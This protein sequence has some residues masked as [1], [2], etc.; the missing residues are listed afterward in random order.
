[1]EFSNGAVKWVSIASLGVF[2]IAYAFSFGPVSWLLLSEIFPDD[3]R[4][5][6]I[7]IAT[8]FNWSGNLAVSFSF[9]SA[10]ESLGFSTTFFIYAGISVL[11]FVF[12][13]S[14]VPE[15]RER[16]LE[17][18]TALLGPSAASPGRSCLPWKQ[19]APSY[20]PVPV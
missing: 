18:I 20:E 6:A 9:L 15:T 19:R 11:A 8:V 7:S 12:I 13:Y 10:L 1:M 5:R 14:Y 4:G 3:A 2:V 17:E 16:T